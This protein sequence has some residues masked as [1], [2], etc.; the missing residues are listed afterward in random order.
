M[1]VESAILDNGTV[2]T[3]HRH[4]D[5]IRI[6]VDLGLPTPIKGVQ[7]F[8]DDKGQFLDRIAAAKHTLECGQITALNWPPNLYSEDL[9]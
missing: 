3:G 5:I 7:G 2:Y 9:W 6:M 1:I 4:P 8:V